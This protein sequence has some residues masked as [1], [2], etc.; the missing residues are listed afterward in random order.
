MNTLGNVNGVERSIK[1]IIDSDAWQTCWEEYWTTKKLI[2]CARTCGRS[3]VVSFA[4]PR[5]QKENV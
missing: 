4:Q 1:D 5:D 3:N 2:T